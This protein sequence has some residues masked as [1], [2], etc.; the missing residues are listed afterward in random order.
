[1]T[2]PEHRA[3]VQTLKL[4]PPTTI[5]MTNHRTQSRACLG[6]RDYL[7]I[8]PDEEMTRD[9]RVSRSDPVEHSHDCTG[10]VYPNRTQVVPSRYLLTR[11]T[12]HLRLEPTADILRSIMV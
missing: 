5:T 8:H 10:W 9:T 2:H 7:L 6:S 12:Q 1:M 4:L 11:D 3:A